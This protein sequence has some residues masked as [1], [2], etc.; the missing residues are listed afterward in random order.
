MEKSKNYIN[1]V[2]YKNA[3]KMDELP[4]ESVTL[5]VTSPPYWN[6]K[7][8]SLDGWQNKKISK[9]IKGQIGDI[10][11][12]DKYLKSMNS[13]WEECYRVLEPSGKLCINVPLMPIL[14][15]ALSTHEARDIVDIAAGIQKE[16]LTN[17][18]FYLY[19]IIIWNRTN[20]SKR[21]MF[22]SYPYPPNFYIQNT[23]EFITIYIKDGKTRKRPDAIKLASRLTE[24]EWVTYTQQVWNIPIPNKN[25]IAYGEHPAIM[26]EEIARRLVKLFSFVD[27][28]ILDPFMG[29][30]T[31]AKVALEERR[32]YTGY[33]IN[34][35]FK[36]L[37]D[38]K[39]AQLNLVTV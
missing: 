26:P 7:D 23:I 39:T 6:V 34:K 21:L 8:Y 12:Y 16:I 14:K 10:N 24:K 19:D 27:D 2:F 37:I 9:K 11:N 35:S 18:K 31:T 17:T 5:V 3:E 32:N 30:G 33:E 28:L 38:A 22:G 36:K 4:N 13:I 29:S 20:P 15:K 1:T 25:D